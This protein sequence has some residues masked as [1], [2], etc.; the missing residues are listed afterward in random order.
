M[1]L[2]GGLSCHNV[3]RREH[4]LPS[5]RLLD[6]GI[7]QTGRWFYGRHLPSCRV[8]LTSISPEVLNLLVD[9]LVDVCENSISDNAHTPTDP[10]PAFLPYHRRSQQQIFRRRPH[11]FLACALSH[12][13]GESCSAQAY[14]YF[15]VLKRL[16]WP[17]LEKFGL[18][19]FW[20]YRFSWNNW[21]FHWR[22]LVPLGHSFNSP[23]LSRS[24]SG[25]LFC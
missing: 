25:Q 3:H 4:P 18:D 23:R 20:N 7:L 24:Q 19:L 2:N 14:S 6:N 1:N 17:V 9:V 16:W 13:Y 22:W 15:S 5:P 10:V 12:P 21:S 11:A 8:H